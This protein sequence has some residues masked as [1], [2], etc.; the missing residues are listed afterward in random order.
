[1]APRGHVRHR[2]GVIGRQIP[3]TLRG[4]RVEAAAAENSGKTLR[5]HFRE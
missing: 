2:D 4:N 3:L 5:K 1:M